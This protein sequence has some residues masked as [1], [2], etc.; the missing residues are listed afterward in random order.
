MR[1]D[2]S[3]DMERAIAEL[4]E[5][6][7]PPIVSLASIAFNYRW[8]WTC[9]G[10][11]LFREIDPATWR[12]VCN[13]RY[14]I[15]VAPPRRLQELARQPEFVGRVRSVAEALLAELAREPLGG[16]LRSERPVAYFCSEFGIHCS[17]PIYGGG[18]GVLAGDFL[19]AAS[20]LRVPMV[21]VGLAY[22]QGYFHQ[23]LD[24]LGWQHEYWVDCNF[25]R[26]PAVRVTGAD[27]G[28]LTVPVRIRG[29]EVRIQVWRIDIGRVPLFLLDTDREDNDTIDRWITSRLYV[30]DRH[31]RL[32]QYAV[33]GVGGV[34]ALRALGITPALVH[35]NEGHAALG[36]LE[37]LRELVAAGLSAGDALERVRHGTVFTT[38]TPVAAGNEGYP[39]NEVEPVLGEFIERSGI[40]RHYVYDL[41]RVG[42][43]NADEPVAITPL[44]LRTS[45]ASNAVSRRHGEVA[46]AMWQ[47]L[48]PERATDAVPIGH[49]T[50]GVHTTTWMA[51]PM[52]QLLDRHLGPDW[53]SRM[54]DPSLWEGLAA[55]PSRELWDIRCT[56]RHA[57]V[58]YVRE[59]SVRDRLAR[60][61]PHEYVEQAAR[62]FDPQVLTIGFA[63]RVATYKRLSL[64]TRFPER[65]LR[66]LADGDMPL[67]LV[68]AGKAHP[69]DMEAKNTLNSIFQMKSAA[70]VG[71]RVVFLEDYDLHMAPRIVSGV[72]VWLNLPRPPLEA[73]GTSGMKVALNGGFNLSVL[74]GWWA[75]AFDGENGW[76]FASPDGDPHEQDDHDAARV[77]DLIE[78]EVL[79]LF[80]DRS[81]DGIPE[82]WVQKVKHAMRTLI[83]AFTAERMLREYVET[84][85][86]PGSIEADATAP[87]PGARSR[88]DTRTGGE[89]PLR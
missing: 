36:G 86:I 27:G 51:T 77:L 32:A 45:R 55:I 24:P 5:R 80:Y 6:L 29:R 42:P 34:R 21:G 30:G 57:L 14:V 3:G 11:D 84:M 74:D 4:G 48:W 28:T 12:R 85:Y 61:E 71:R 62:V 46:R 20:D 76:G 40:A 69:Q 75:E 81:A 73:S 2:G 52:Q 10:A 87:A 41:G 38:H 88:P 17:L 49:V 79:P 56:L 59:H 8:A 72:D 9:G 13:P 35:L 58:E 39:E 19:K 65:N 50:N 78:G 43:G 63:R 66:L 22:R 47:P 83:P 16:A 23:R 54:A 7:P 15:E 60:G 70:N 89:T 44:A 68:I 18:L 53:R 67:Q 25:E 26:L 1:H 31:T 82:R 37:R 33:L 64:L